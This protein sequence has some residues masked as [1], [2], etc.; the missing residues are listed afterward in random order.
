MGN[1]FDTQVIMSQWAEALWFDPDMI[2]GMFEP[3]L[4]RACGISIP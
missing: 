2:R 3:E 4:E 1:F